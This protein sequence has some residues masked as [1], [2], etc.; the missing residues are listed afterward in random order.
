MNHKAAATSEDNER[1][2]IS[3][4]RSAQ[5]AKGKLVAL[6]IGCPLN[7]YSEA[8]LLYDKRLLPLTKKHEWILSLSD[9]ER[10]AIYSAHCECMEIKHSKFDDSN[11]A[12]KEMGAW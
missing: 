6:V 7:D 9:R 3:S 12:I 2:I 1:G 11:K 10:V 4:K 8:C 5:L